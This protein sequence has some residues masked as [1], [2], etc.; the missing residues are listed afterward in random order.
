MTTGGTG[1]VCG[2]PSNQT[3]LERTAH[4]VKKNE[5]SWR[6]AAPQS[7][8]ALID[9]VGGPLIKK[10]KAKA[11]L[12]QKA[13]LIW[14]ESRERRGLQASWHWLKR[15]RPGTAQNMPRVRARKFG[16]SGKQEKIR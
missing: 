16:H 14:T 3:W 12:R 8:S 1:Y 11:L 10:Q 9:Q 15:R 13:K 4:V 5:R 7:L 6:L 2:T